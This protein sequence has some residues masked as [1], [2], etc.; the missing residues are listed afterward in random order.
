MDTKLAGAARESR[1]RRRARREHLAAHKMRYDG[2]W[3]FVD[4]DWNGIVGP[5]P[6]HYG[7][8]PEKVRYA[9]CLSQS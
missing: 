7:G 4:N 1:L 3:F 5:P 9:W 6:L 8:G 2:T